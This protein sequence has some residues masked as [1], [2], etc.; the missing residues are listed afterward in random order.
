MRVQL[1]GTG[2]ADGIPNPFCSCRTCRTALS[3]GEVRSQSAALVDDVLL[4]DCGPDVPRAASRFGSSL[5]GVQHLLLTHSHP[6]HAGPTAALFRSWAG[7]STSLDLVGPAQALDVFRDWVGPDDPVRF[8]TVEPGQNLRL[9]GYGVRVLA[10]A[11]G[12]TMTGPGLLYDV[13]GPDGGRLLYATDTGPLPSATVGALTGC[14]FDL[15]LLEETFG[16]RTGHG[17]D[18]LDLSTFP[19]AV[20]ALRDVGAA[21]EQTDLVAVHLGHH[22]PPTAELGER[23]R[24]SGARVVP[25]GTVLVVG[26]ATPA[27]DAVRAPAPSPRQTLVLGGARSGKST[28]AEAVA[29]RLAT[30]SPVTYL[31]TGGSRVDDAEWAERVRLHQARRPASWATVETTDLVAQLDRATSGDVLLIDC[32]SLWLAAVLDAAGAWT[33]DDG[34]AHERAAAAV[35]ADIA[36]LVDALGHTAGTVVAVSNEVGSG[37]VPATASGRTYRDLLGRLNVA[38]AQ[39]AADVVLVVAGLPI[40]LKAQDQPNGMPRR[41]EP[42]R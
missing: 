26:A 32:L 9:G 25:D 28:H 18:H 33:A 24:P 37:V 36:A 19:A 13:S 40:V 12:D 3:T 30:D 4:L 27:K 1:L 11:H 41:M 35:D 23:L 16:D 7:C 20:Q 15:V 38:V 10:A 39:V 17:T 42:H 31:A 29:G 21:T 5:A 2:S 22:N 34:P 6:D 8:V 14:A